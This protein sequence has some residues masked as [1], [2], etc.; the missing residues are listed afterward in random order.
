MDGITDSMDMSLSKF[1]ETEKNREAWHAAWGCKES[2]TTVMEQQLTGYVILLKV[3]P[4]P[5]P[6]CF[7][8]TE[9]LPVFHS[10]PDC[11]VCLTAVAG[12]EFSAR[13]ASYMEQD[14][15]LFLE[16]TLKYLG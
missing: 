16:V 5:L 8:A 9:N 7:I 12:L 2:D 11:S 13:L 6:F 1:W 4:C 10:T 3:L 15:P 14:H